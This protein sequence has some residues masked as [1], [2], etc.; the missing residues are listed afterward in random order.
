TPHDLSAASRLN[1]PCHDWPIYPFPKSDLPWRSAAA[2][3]WSR[4]HEIDLVRRSGFAFRYSHH[5]ASDH[6]RRTPSR[7]DVRRRLSRLQG[8]LAT[9]DL[10]SDHHELRLR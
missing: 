3:L 4:N 10:I 9:L 2:S 8:S 1:K 5:R 6:S 7:S